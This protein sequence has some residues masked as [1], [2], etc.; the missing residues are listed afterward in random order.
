MRYAEQLATIQR[1]DIPPGQSRRFD[2]PACRGPK[3][4]SVTK[5]T[6]NLIWNCFRAGCG[7]RGRVGTVRTRSDL[8]ELMR[9]PTGDTIPSMSIPEGWVLPTHHPDVVIWMQRNHV[10]DAY[11][12]KR[13]DIR[14]DPRQNRVVFLVRE[15]STGRVVDAAG[16]SLT[17]GVKPKW[18]RYGRSGLPFVCPKDNS[19]AV[20]VEDCASAC[21]V[22]A[23]ATGVALLGV[24]LTDQSL[25]LLR[26]YDRAIIA[27]DPD[28]KMKS[29][30]LH[31]LAACYATT[32][33]RFI[34]D[35]LK[36]FDPPR[37]KRELG[38]E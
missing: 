19:V 14:Y 12:H 15:P 11:A 38:L 17:K 29:L 13:V 7:I 20:V 25:G 4:L 8:A 26:N 37:I 1:Y 9:Q 16:R 28:A 10:W 31:R 27:L 18:L 5:E 34:S 30:Q 3:T 35:D 36:Y 22:S 6:G 24:S 33:V 21:A 32:S 23:V 2:C